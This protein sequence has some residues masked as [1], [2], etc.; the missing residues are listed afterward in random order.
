MKNAS[1]ITT[2]IALLVGAAGGYFIGNKGSQNDVSGNEIQN[3]NVISGT[4]LG[5][6]YKPS[7]S[8]SSKDNASTDS[9]VVSVDGNL[10]AEARRLFDSGDVS[11]ALQ[12]ILNAPGQMGRMEALLGFVKTLDAEGV[13]AALPFVRGMG[14]GGDQFMSMGLLMGRYAEIDPERALTYVGK[15]GG[16][17][18]GFGTSSILRTWAASD[19]RAAADYLSNNVL[20]SG[21]DDWMLRRTAG[22]LASEWAKQ[23][24]DAALAWATGLPD[25]VKGDAMNNIVEQLTSQ[26]PLEAAKVAMGFEGEQRERSMRTIADQWSRNEPEDAVK[27]A[28]SLTVEGKTQAIEE[29]VENWV[30]KDTDA[31][32]AYMDNMDQGERDAIMKEVVEQWGRKGSEAQPAAAEWVASQPDGKGKVDATGEIVGQWMRSDAVAASDWLNGQ[33]E[34]DA[35]DRGISALLRDRSVREDPE[36]AV[37]WA[38]SISNQEMRSEQVERSARSWLASDRAAA[39]E[40]LEQSNS[41]SAEQ[42]TEL[43][44]LS[45]EELNRGREREGW[46]GRGRPF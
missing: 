21:G 36:A 45:P 46:R 7:R 44:N 23:D 29:A 40:Y 18:R 9:S 2:I 30:R 26:D 11:G 28:E 31:A 3:E 25:E 32:V 17:E 33:P 13:E 42:K 10:A 37:A 14:R 43:I 16:M 1:L 22:S 39:L 8:S 38:D 12:K 15:Q 6:S 24:S 4:G 20:G 5:S 41:L 35:K 34:G 27:W 19:P